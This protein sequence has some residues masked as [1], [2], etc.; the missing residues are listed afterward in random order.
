MRYWQ[1]PL[2]SDAPEVTRP[3][4]VEALHVLGREVVEQHLIS[5]APLGLFLS[6]GVDSAALAALASEA[7]PAG[8]LRA[9]TIGF[10]SPGFDESRAAAQTASYF[11]INQETITVTGDDVLHSIGGALAAIDQPTVDGFNTYFVSRFA[12]A[13]GL[14]TALSGLG[15]DELFAG[16]DSFT[17]VPRAVAL[18]KSVVGNW[19]VRIGKS[20]VPG[21]AGLKLAES[22]R[23]EPDDLVMYLLRRELFLPDERR[24]LQSLPCNSDAITGVPAELMVEMKAAAAGMD[25]INRVSFYELHLYMRH[26]LLRDADVFSM[27]A[28]I[29]Y[30][31]PFLDH[32]FVEAVFALPGGWKRRDTRPKPL[33]LDL[34]G[35]RIPEVVW[36]RRKQGFAFPWGDWFKPGGALSGVACEAV[37]DSTTWRNLGLDC[38]GVI[39]T[40]RRFAA[41]DRSV[42]PLQV[43]AFVALRDFA[44]R[45]QLYLT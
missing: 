38:R 18:R 9:F 15:G 11:G 40:W 28:P 31:V 4:A 19:L 44:V 1:L 3:E 8:S 23:R 45:H 30:R 12:R 16:Y 25:E 22:F 7:R 27:A 36:K 41:G 26:M 39:S 5:D 29:E 6:G 10:N 35:Q 43:L 21:R 17:D 20:M 24:A 37:N 32:S 34:V 2:R 33:L 42:S 14:S 13:A